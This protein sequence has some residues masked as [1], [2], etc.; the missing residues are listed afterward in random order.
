MKA[1]ELAGKPA[2]AT[3]SS[4]PAD[5]CTTLA[6]GSTGLTTV[7]R[8]DAATNSVCLVNSCRTEAER[9]AA[10]E[11]PVVVFVGSPEG[12][13]ADDAGVEEGAVV[14]PPDIGA[15]VMTSKLYPPIVAIGFSPG[16]AAR[17]HSHRP[18]F[19]PVV[20][21][22]LVLLGVV[23][24]TLGG[25][26]ASNPAKHTAVGVMDSSVTVNTVL[27]LPAATVIAEGPH[28]VPC[29][30]DWKM[31][32]I[33]PGRGGLLLLAV[34]GELLLPTLLG[35]PLVGPVP[36]VDGL[37]RFD[38]SVGAGCPFTPGVPEQPVRTSVTIATV[39]AMNL[40]CRHLKQ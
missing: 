4:P 8:P 25:L 29:G 40:V 28:E 39:I 35:E 3:C 10:G 11:L 18:L 37:V 34:P 22:Y 24:I 15:D 9:S 30:I 38:E 20:A 32:E 17:V 16:P 31:D 6:V 5:A 36:S 1:G 13:E 14:E 7:N 21:V 27:E 2:K 33:D 12:T 23:I 26:D 19:C